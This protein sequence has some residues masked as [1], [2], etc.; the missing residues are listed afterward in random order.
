MY[1][2]SS[3]F[4]NIRDDNFKAEGRGFS[5]V[6]EIFRPYFQFEVKSYICWHLAC[7]FNFLMGGAFH[8]QY[9]SINYM[10]PLRL[11]F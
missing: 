7:S 3:I 6:V 10:G 4:C 2:T 1:G 9:P 11:V 8:F 5:N